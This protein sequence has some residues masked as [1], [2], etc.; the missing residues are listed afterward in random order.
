MFLFNENLPPIRIL[1]VDPG[2]RVT[3]YGVVDHRQGRLSLVEA[4]VIRTRSSQSIAERLRIIHEGLS[5]LIKETEPGVLALEKL[6]SD[7]RHPTTAILMGHARGVICLTAGETGIPLANL[8]STRVKKAILSHGHAGKD[9][10]GRAIQ[11]MLDIKHPIRPADV[12]DALAVAV[13][14]ALTRK[15]EL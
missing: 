5:D 7:Y 10:I 12:T 9:Q 14:Y 6:Y 15:K 8:P 3:G 11:G 2:L 1:G 4:G 13:S